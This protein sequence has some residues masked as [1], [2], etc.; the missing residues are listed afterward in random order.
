MMDVYV[1]GIGPGN[2]EYLTDR[3][4]SAIAACPVLVGD[5]RMVE[6]YAAAGKRLVY[7]YKKM[8]YMSWPCLS[9]RTA[10]LWLSSYRATSGFTV[11]RLSS[12]TC[13]TVISSAYP[14]SAVW[15]ISPLSCRRTGMIR[16]LSAAMAAAIP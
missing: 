15:C 3:A 1:I 6:P 5:R 9:F 8:K 10:A 14:A 13:R 12:G 4:R 2:P 11:W 7:T 16:I